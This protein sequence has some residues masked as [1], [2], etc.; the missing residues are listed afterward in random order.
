MFL[1]LLPCSLSCLSVEILPNL[2]FSFDFVLSLLLGLSG[3]LFLTGFL[4]GSFLLG[5]LGCGLLLG[6]QGSCSFI[7]F[8]LFLSL[9]LSLSCSL[10]LLSDEGDSRLLSRSSSL[11]PIFPCSLDLDLES[12][13]VLGTMLDLI[14]LLLSKV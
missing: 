6:F 9:L 7:S 3:S 10:K 4:G 12:K 11:F 13:L 1:S 2:S 14:E 8:A 5:L